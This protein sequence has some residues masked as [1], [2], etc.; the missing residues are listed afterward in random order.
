MA[1]SSERSATI[2]FSFRFSS[3]SCL[4][5]RISDAP[6]LPPRTFASS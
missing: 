2:A 1:L 6:S 3:S 5:R 4:S